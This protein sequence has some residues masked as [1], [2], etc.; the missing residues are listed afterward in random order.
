ML[1]QVRGERGVVRGAARRA[2]RAAGRAVVRGNGARGDRVGGNGAV[3]SLPAAVVGHSLGDA[4]CGD[5]PGDHRL[6]G[7]DHP[8]RPAPAAPAPLSAGTRAAPRL[9]P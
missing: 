8:Q 7:Y 2:G 6:A 1:F 9:L 5:Q 3:P 4:G